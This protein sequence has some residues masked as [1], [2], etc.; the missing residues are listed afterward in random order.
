MIK[1]V[2]NLVGECTECLLLEVE[3]NKHVFLVGSMYRIPNTCI[4]Q[5]NDDLRMLLNKTKR[6][7]NCIIGSDQNLDL[8]R[9]QHDATSKFVDLITEYQFIPTIN[10][11]TRVTHT[12]ATLI[13]NLF[14]KCNFHKSIKV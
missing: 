9:Y 2:F 6:Y 10:K 12:S 14:L 5:F 3:I 13:E 4:G 1:E 8:K 11:P 7:S